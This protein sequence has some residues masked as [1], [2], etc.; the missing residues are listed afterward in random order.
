MRGNR[1]DL[2]NLQKKISEI[3]FVFFDA[4]RTNNRPVFIVCSFENRK[5]L[6]CFC[7]M[8]DSNFCKLSA[9]LDPFKC[10]FWPVG[11]TRDDFFLGLQEGRATKLKGLTEYDP[12][13]FK[14]WDA[15]VEVAN[16]CPQALGTSF[17][18]PAWMAGVIVEQKV[19]W[20]ELV[21]IS[22]RFCSWSFQF[23]LSEVESSL[24]PDLKRSGPS[25]L[26]H[27][28]LPSAYT[29]TYTKN[30]NFAGLVN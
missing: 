24:L 27:Y 9:L 25:V 8:S 5:Q 10:W 21:Y 4:C 29:N 23:I 12:L 1:L 16:T 19:S 2:T 18:L 14:F 26:C 11:I 7:Q 20:E 30:L 6:D 28:R 3:N 22:S 13:Q 15:V 17:G